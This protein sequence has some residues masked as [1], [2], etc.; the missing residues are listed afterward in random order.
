M[1]KM[2][3]LFLSNRFSALIAVI[4]VAI[5]HEG[6]AFVSAP[7][8]IQIPQPATRHYF[9]SEPDAAPSAL[10]HADIKWKI[11]PKEGTPFVESKKW[12]VEA[13]LMRMGY[14]EKQKEIPL[15]YFPLTWGQ[16]LLEAWKDDKRIGRFGITCNSGP[17]APLIE[18]TISDIYGP[19]A[20]SQDLGIAA[21]IYMFCEPEYRGRSI[22]VLAL[23]VISLIHHTI[24]CNYTLLV[25]DDKSDS[26]TLVNWYERHGY[27]RAPKLQE[28]MGSPGGQFGVTMIGPTN[29]GVPEDLC[30]EWW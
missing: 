12:Q 17:S 2:P 16:L 20:V 19:S 18:E 10:G 6:V 5:L 1:E 29:D 15:I 14:K 8:R 3:S 4:S 13:N 27:S 25:A 28:F 22:G 30:I 9:S 7:R 21:I 24:G 26:G 23:E 11:K